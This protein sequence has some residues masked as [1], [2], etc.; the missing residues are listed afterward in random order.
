MQD[1]HEPILPK[2]VERVP[3]NATN[4][5]VISIAD[6]TATNNGVQDTERL[7]AIAGRGDVTSQLSEYIETR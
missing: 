7:S 5:E 3:L 6:G 4:L 1:H 2:G